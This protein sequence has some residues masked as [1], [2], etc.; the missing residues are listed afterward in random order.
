VHLI[1]PV[2]TDFFLRLND[3]TM[4]LFRAVAQ[5]R[6]VLLL[7]IDASLKFDG[8]FEW[9]DLNAW[10]ITKLNGGSGRPAGL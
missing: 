1:S 10:R 9:I 3:K 8:K 4:S 7:I 5:D 2:G 6:G